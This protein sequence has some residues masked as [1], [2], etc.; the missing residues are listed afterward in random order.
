MEKRSAFR[1][2]ARGR[3]AA[4]AALLLALGLP[5]G[6]G[7]DVSEDLAI[8]V[9]PECTAT[10][11]VG[12]LV[13]VSGAVHARTADGRLRSLACDD[14]LRACETLVTSPGA[15]AGLLAQDVYAEVTPDTRV[16]VGL[17]EGLPEFYVQ[18]GGVRL[19]D[20]REGGG[21]PLEVGTPHGSGRATGADS[22]WWV[23][24]EGGAGET[25]VC[26][27]ERDV[28]LQPLSGAGGTAAAG[29]CAVLDTGGVHLAEGADP[30]IAI[31]AALTCDFDVAGELSPT[32][33]AAPP[34]GFG[35]FPDVLAA[36]AF[37]RSPC[38]DPGSGCRGPV[39]PTPTPTPPPPI[40]KDFTPDSP[41]GGDFGCVDLD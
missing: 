16:R 7:A 2:R 19:V 20:A 22:E 34:F 32:D 36:D 27:H 31:A 18:S 1:Q 39:T 11:D 14:V 38:D 35:A 21:A 5:G 12:Q 13:A 10:G 24:F 3:I 28:A 17:R 37:Q 8:G 9:P 30:T 33:V 40:A 29:R 4:G 26:A 25:R 15:R 23:R 41:C 6:A